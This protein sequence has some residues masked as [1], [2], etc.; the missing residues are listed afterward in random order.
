MPSHDMY[1]K[2]MGYLL[3][4]NFHDLMD[5]SK[6]YSTFNKTKSLNQG[7]MDQNQNENRESN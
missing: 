2:C 5:T 3:L 1:P 4:R 7:Q 6:F